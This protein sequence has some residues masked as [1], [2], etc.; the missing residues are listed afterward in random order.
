VLDCTPL[1]FLSVTRCS[2]VVHLVA[3]QIG[4]MLGETLS[5][6]SLLVGSWVP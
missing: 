4:R 6:C 1:C 3:T 5:T 2:P